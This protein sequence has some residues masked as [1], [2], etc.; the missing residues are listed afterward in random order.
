MHSYA[1]PLIISLWYASN[2]LFNV[3]MKQCYSTLP[4]TIALTSLQL[5]ATTLLL[6]P[7]LCLAYFIIGS[8][9]NWL[10]LHRVVPALVQQERL[11]G[12][13]RHTHAE[14]RIL[15][16]SAAFSGGTLADRARASRVF[17]SVVSNQHRVLL[18]RACPHDHC[19]GYPSDTAQV[20][21]ERT[22][23]LPL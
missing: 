6:A 3:G 12:E 21:R 18:Q 17:R 8:L 1:T 23:R 2:L 10:L 13:F 4:D 20:L 15:A 11:E 9:P 16:E 7:A 5:L 22:V 14:I 19:S